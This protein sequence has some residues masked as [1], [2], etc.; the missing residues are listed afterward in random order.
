MKKQKNVI[1]LSLILFCNINVALRDS[2]K[3]LEIFKNKEAGL[4]EKKI[5][6][7]IQFKKIL[8]LGVDIGPEYLMFGR[9][10]QVDVDSNQN[11]FIL[12]FQNHRILKF[13]RKGEF[14]WKAGKKGQGP[15]EIESPSFI[16]VTDEGGVVLADQGVILSFFDKDGNYQRR[17]KFEKSIKSIISFSDGHI[18]ANLFK[19]GQL[20]IVA[21]FFSADGK[22]INYFPIKYYYGPKLSPSRAYNL[23]GAFRLFNNNLYLSLPDKYE[24][25]EYSLEGKLLRKIKRNIK[26][27][28]PFLEDGYKFIFRDISGP[29]YFTSKGF[30]I[31]KLYL[32]EKIDE[33]I[34]K[35]YLDFFNKDLKY[36][37]SYLIQEDMYLTSIDK[38]DNFYFVQKD[39]YIKIIKCSLMIK[40]ESSLPYSVGN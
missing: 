17:V 9:N 13:D 35:T 32:K 38:Y 37:G 11:I 28:P 12:D 2:N 39:P 24:I 5:K 7:K 20:G 27:R 22:L 36:L 34:G 40:L 26:I 3:K 16:K 1:F 31:N 29:C 25:R 23:G 8:S 33:D 19:S 4:Y 6:N 18:L 30:I 14:Q 21:A 10:I 15:G